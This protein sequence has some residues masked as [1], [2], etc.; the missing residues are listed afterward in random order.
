[1]EIDSGG[2][3]TELRARRRLR[4]KRRR[5]GGAGWGELGLTFYREDGRS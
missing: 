5:R 3:P 4:A 2:D 1:M